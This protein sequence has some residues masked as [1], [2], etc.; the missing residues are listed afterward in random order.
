MAA[1]PAPAVRALQEDAAAVR[2]GGGQAGA[3]AHPVRAA[4]GEGCHR[5]ALR[6]G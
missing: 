5:A 4:G 3:G 1:R 6:A 2:G